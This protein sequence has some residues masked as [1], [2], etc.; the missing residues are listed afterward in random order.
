MNLDPENVVLS[1]N[2]VLGLESNYHNLDDL[3]VYR[4]IPFSLNIMGLILR[5]KSFKSTAFELL[6]DENCVLCAV[7]KRSGAQGGS[8]Y[9][10]YS[11]SLNKINENQEIAYLTSNFSGTKFKLFVSKHGLRF[12]SVQKDEKLELARI[13][14]ETNVFGLNG[15][16]KMTVSI[17]C[18]DLNGNAVLKYG[19]N[20]YLVLKNKPPQWSDATNTF[21]LNFNGRV[22]QPSAKNF[23]LIHEREKSYIIMQFGRTNNGSFILDCQFPISILQAFAC[24]LSSF[25]QKLACE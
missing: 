16:R 2:S 23:Q 25:D 19:K 15:P 7:K 12:F 21:V 18:V 9:N 11:C 5:F 20:E 14:Y 6:I 3:Y 4:P 17:P 8:I 1:F 22:S 13:K 10:I 24:C